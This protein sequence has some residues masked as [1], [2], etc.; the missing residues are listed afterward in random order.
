MCY[1]L[2]PK[3]GQVLVNTPWF[4]QTARCVANA[5]QWTCYSQSF[6]MKIRSP[7]Y[8]RRPSLHH[9][10]F[11]VSNWN[12]KPRPQR[13]LIKRLLKLTMR[14]SF[15][16]EKSGGLVYL[17]GSPSTSCS[18]NSEIFLLSASC[19]RMG[20][21]LPKRFTLRRS[22]TLKKTICFVSEAT[23]K[24]SPMA[25][26]EGPHKVNNHEWFLDPMGWQ[27]FNQKKKKKSLRISWSLRKYLIHRHC[28][29]FLLP[30]LPWVLLLLIHSLLLFPSP[31]YPGVPLLGPP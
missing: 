9:V 12:P 21:T 3:R 22:T 18:G 8:E 20:N 5:C 16:I 23:Y 26:H 28:L 30:P 27:D 31:P 15:H 6:A 14:T 24:N 2:P 19:R 11:K 7:G 4:P 13:A 10:P 17:P 1:K 29:S 25:T